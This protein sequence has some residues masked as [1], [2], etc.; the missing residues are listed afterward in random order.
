M[1]NETLIELE[2]AF[3][4]ALN[5]AP[6]TG[7]LPAPV[8]SYQGALGK[9]LNEMLAGS[10]AMFVVFAGDAYTALDNRNTIYDSAIDFDVL[11]TCRNLRGDLAQRA[12]AANEIGIYEMLDDARDALAGKRLGLAIQPLRLI[13]RRVV[14]TTPAGAVWALRVQTRFDYVNT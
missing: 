7:Y 14:I 8:R 2:N 12:G 5:V 1:A 13:R 11:V 6:M 3:I 9:S 4:A 10:P